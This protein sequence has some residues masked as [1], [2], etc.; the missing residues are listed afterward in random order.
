MFIFFLYSSIGKTRVK[1]NNPKS[2]M[3]ITKPKDISLIPKT[4]ELAL[5][6]IETPRYGQSSGITV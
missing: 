6:L 4:R 1:W 3:I 2:V 5:W